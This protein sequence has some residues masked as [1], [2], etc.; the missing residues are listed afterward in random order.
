MSD[1]AAR[2]SLR[3]QVLSIDEI[4]RKHSP[5]AQDAEAAIVTKAR[6]DLGLSPK[7]STPVPTSPVTPLSPTPLRTP[8]PGDTSTLAPLHDMT[9][10]R[11]SPSASTGNDHLGRSKEDLEI[12]GES[13]EL[14]MRDLEIGQQ[15][16]DKLERGSLASSGNSGPKRMS[17]NLP[18]SPTPQRSSGAATPTGTPN[19]DELSH[20]LARYL[21][22][23]SLNRILTLPRPFPERPL[24]VSLAEV[25]DLSGKP[26]LVFLGL[27]CARHL[28]AMYDDLA[29]ALGLRLICIDRWGYGK[30][31]PMTEE[32]GS[33]MRWAWVVEQVM[34]RLE[35]DR[36]QL[37]AHSAGAAYAVAVVLRIPERVKGT[38]YFLAP[39]VSTEIDGGEHKVFKVFQC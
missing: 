17:F 36:F 7:P 24:R 2:S 10:Q 35:V 34:D 11:D 26:V 20:S 19:K 12:T 4:I 28:I 27:G 29:K 6:L 14:V 16:L 33:I 1:T 38:L 39:W 30:T 3:P 37:M 31:D 25:G 21:R 8:R 15:L 22:S 32:H 5:A 23:P 13:E 18:R 9:S